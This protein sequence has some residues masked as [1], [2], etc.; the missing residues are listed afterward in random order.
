MQ[1]AVRL[2]LI[3]VAAMALGCAARSQAPEPAQAAAQ[4]A[5]PAQ[6]AAQTRSPER[7]IY[8]SA[9]GLP[10]ACYHE[11]G[12]IQF[13]EPFTDAAIDPDNSKAAERLRALALQ[14]YPDK[15]DAVIGLHT[16]E[17]DVGTVTTVIG[18]AVELRQGTS[19][20]CAMRR[21]PGALDTVAASAA[22]GVVGALAGGLAG[23]GP[24]TAMIGGAAGV[25]AVGS[26]LAYKHH[27]EAVAEHDR[28]IAQL[29]A[30]RREIAELQA[31]RETLEQCRAQDTPLDKCNPAP[32]P[33]APSPAEAHAA[34]AADW[35][36]PPYE[37]QRQIQEQQVYIKKLREE[38]AE[39]RHQLGAN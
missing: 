6:G 8:V 3:V 14:Q 7:F 1:Q 5:P 28:L 11:L 31:E 26:Y 29:Q 35:S 19:V 27:K 24:T 30:Q 25:T 9:Q 20:E 17:N 21:V 36:A 38:I 18:E 33:A 37:L 16:K 4:P 32:A 22:G 15:V 13:N 12:V 10:G 39:A 23:G 34:E 2:V